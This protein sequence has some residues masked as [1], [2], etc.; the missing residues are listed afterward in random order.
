MNTNEQI[1]VAVAAG[2]L[3]QRARA[4][5]GPVTAGVE[6]AFREMAKALH[7]DAGGDPTRFRALLAARDQLMK[8]MAA[9]EVTFHKIPEAEHP[10]KE[11]LN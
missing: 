11:Q 2:K 5:G 3:L 10:K 4:L 1:A 7:P 6:R 8:R 9:L